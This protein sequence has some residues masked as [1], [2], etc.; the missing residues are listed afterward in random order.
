MRLGANIFAL[1]AAASFPYRTFLASSSVNGSLKDKN[2]K[3]RGHCWPGDKKM[4][5][6][7][8]TISHEGGFWHFPSLYQNDHSFSWL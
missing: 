1:I 4:S 3:R 8:L 5:Y 7:A 2:L 6:V